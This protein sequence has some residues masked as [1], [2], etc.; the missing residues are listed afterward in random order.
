[1]CKTLKYTVSFIIAGFCFLNLSAQTITLSAEIIW[2]EKDVY[3]LNYDKENVPFLKFTYRNNS[4]NSLYFYHYTDSTAFLSYNYL[5]PLINYGSNI[6]P[7]PWKLLTDSLP[8]WSGKNYNVLIVKNDDFYF[9]YGSSSYLYVEGSQ[10]IED[11]NELL[12][13]D[14]YELLQNLTSLLQAQLSLNNESANLQYEYF[15]YPD[16]DTITDSY[17]QERVNEA[18]ENFKLWL[19]SDERKLEFAERDSMDKGLY[20]NGVSDRVLR[21]IEKDIEHR[22]IFLKPRES[23]SF[24]FDLTPFFLLKG[25]YNFIFKSQKQPESVTFRNPYVIYKAYPLNVHNPRDNDNFYTFNLPLTHKGYKLYTGEVNEV[26]VMLNVPS[27]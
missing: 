13:Y 12:Y 15:H 27:N 4:D 17:M 22:C 19:D 9:P 14:K 11:S 25:S 8:D 16:K 18:E 2:K 26:N 1:M 21:L 5:R 24:E 6:P 7:N 20:P 23:F 3:F 10:L